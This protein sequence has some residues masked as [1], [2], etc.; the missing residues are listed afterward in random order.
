[1]PPLMG[2]LATGALDANAQ[3]GQPAADRGVLDEVTGQ[4]RDLKKGLDALSG[5]LPQSGAT[6]KQINQLLQRLLIDAAKSSPQQNA[7]AEALPGGGG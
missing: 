7:S 3:G 6:I 4:I 5:K 2:N 1:M